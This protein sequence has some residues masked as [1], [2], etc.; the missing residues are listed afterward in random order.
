MSSPTRPS[1][2]LRMTRT[3]RSLAD[4]GVKRVLVI[5][6]EEAI[7]VALAKF[8]RS[9][10]YEVQTAESSEVAL[11]ILAIERF[12]VLLCDVRMPGSAVST[13][14]PAPSPSTPTS[15]SSC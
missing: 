7:R 14:C 6:D 13:S 15:R 8:L 3:M 1:Q 5:D 9:R 2:M 10:G 12:H 11:D 4:T